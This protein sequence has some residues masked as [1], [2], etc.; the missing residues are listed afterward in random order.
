M[1]SSLTRNQIVAFILAFAISFALYLF[2][3]VV[4]IVPPALQPLLAFLS[5]DNHFETISRG[6]IDTPR[7]LL[8]PVGHRRQPGGRHRLPRIPQ[9]EVTP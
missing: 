8:L 1:A 2:G 3:R 7:R 5:I 6:V 4:Q 9:V